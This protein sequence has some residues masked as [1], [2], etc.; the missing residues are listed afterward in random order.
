VG[1]V[2]VGYYCALL[3]VCAC[4]SGCVLCALSGGGCLVHAADHTQNTKIPHKQPI[5]CVYIKRVPQGSF[6]L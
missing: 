4:V 3:C 1:F 6:A 2:C 5:L